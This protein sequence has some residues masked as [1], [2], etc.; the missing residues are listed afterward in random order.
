HVADG[1]PLHTIRRDSPMTAVAWSVDGQSLATVA[2]NGTVSFWNRAGQQI[3]ELK[4][5]KGNLLKG[6][7][8]SNDIHVLLSSVDD[9]AQAASQR[10]ASQSYEFV[11]VEHDGRVLTTL[12]GYNGRLV[13]FAWTPDG[14]E[15]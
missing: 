4:D 15:F 8:L 7:A 9:P 1:Q 10:P 13:S 6:I 12:S 5:F 3:R 2:D 14:K 11:D